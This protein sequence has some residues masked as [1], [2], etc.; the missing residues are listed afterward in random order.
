MASSVMELQLG[1]FSF[2]PATHV[3]TKSKV[4]KNA[5]AIF[6]HHAASYAYFVFTLRLQYKQVTYA[7]DESGLFWSREKPGYPQLEP[8]ALK[9]MA[10]IL[11][12]LVYIYICAVDQTIEGQEVRGQ[13]VYMWRVT[14]KSTGT[15]SWLLLVSDW[16]TLK[17]KE[18]NLEACHTITQSI[19]NNT[20]LEPLILKLYI[21]LSTGLGLWSCN[22]H[23][24][25]S[26]TSWLENAAASLWLNSIYSKPVTC[27][28]GSKVPFVIAGHILIH[29]TA[30]HEK[31]K[32]TNLPCSLHFLN[33]RCGLYFST[34]SRTKH[35]TQSFIFLRW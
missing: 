32:L 16:Q 12:S 25:I 19:Q 15:L 6:T 11:K 20:V 7:P 26:W 13:L 9:K 21:A 24:I 28:K 17:T 23:P 22:L 2:L 35:W 18:S 27:S 34:L 30:D 10:Q 4:K 31:N 29:S 1:V 5:S 33:P 8:H 3:K 14:A